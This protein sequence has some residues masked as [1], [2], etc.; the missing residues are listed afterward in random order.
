[1]LLYEFVFKQI[2]I[3]HK[4]YFITGGS[5]EPQD[6]DDNIRSETFKLDRTLA[7]HIYFTQSEHGQIKLMRKTIVILWK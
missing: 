2:W 1:M 7:L 5:Y 4:V 3:I 6:Q